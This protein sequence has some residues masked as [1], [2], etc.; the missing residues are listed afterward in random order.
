MRWKWQSDSRS[1]WVDSS[2]CVE[3]APQEQRKPGALKTKSFTVTEDEVMSPAPVVAKARGRGA[4]T[5]AKDGPAAAGGEDRWQQEA[6]Q[7]V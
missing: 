1:W 7:G 5:A 6:S 3:Q 4:A 2:I